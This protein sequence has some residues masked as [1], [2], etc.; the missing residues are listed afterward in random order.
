MARQIGVLLVDLTLKK[1]V[2]MKTCCKDEVE[3]EID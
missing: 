3:D 1:E 2:D